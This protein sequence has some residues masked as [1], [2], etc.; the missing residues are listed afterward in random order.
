VKRVSARRPASPPTTWRGETW[1]IAAVS[2]VGA[3]SWLAQFDVEPPPGTLLPLVDLLLGLGVIVALHW[4]RRWP[5]PIGVAAVLATAVSALAIPAAAVIV[6]SLVTSR[7][8]RVAAAV[9]GLGALAAVPSAALA[10]ADPDDEL[11][12]WVLLTGGAV[13]Y[14][15]AFGVGLYIRARRELAVSRREREETAEREQAS[16]LAEAQANE[17][18][19]IAREMHDVLAHRISLV[20]MHAGAMTYRTD[21]TRDQ[22]LDSARVVQDNAHQALADL[23]DVLGVLRDP[24][25]GEPGFG[26]LGTTPQR[27]Q[28]TLAAL[29][30]LVTEVRAAGAEVT[31]DPTTVDLGSVPDLVGRSAYRIIQEALTNARKHAPGAAVTIRLSGAPDDRLVV[32]VTNP[33][34]TLA[35]TVPTRALLPGAGVGLIGLQERAELAG[36]ELTFREALD[37]TFRVRAWLP[38]PR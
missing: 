22:L 27:P 1:R 19:R 26:E 17:R 20:A 7:G 28:P 12:W 5:V 18:A 35:A 23:R 34:Q 21:L 30:E 4:R 33:V 9:A 29:P 32:E 2:I 38:W 6:A 11:Q 15:I 13:L 10:P 3:L 14:G 37:G 31:L 16:R 24:G 36:G 25:S 8:W